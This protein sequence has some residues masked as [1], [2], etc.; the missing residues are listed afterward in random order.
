MNTIAALHIKIM[1]SFTR[2]HKTLPKWLF[3]FAFP[4]AMDKTS[5][6]LFI[7]MFLHIFINKY[8]QISSFYANDICLVVLFLQIT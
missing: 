5:L 4:L 3:D 1:F 8:Y 2:N 6:K 7:K